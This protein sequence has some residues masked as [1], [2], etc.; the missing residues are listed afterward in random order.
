MSSSLSST[1][2]QARTMETFL[3]RRPFTANARSPS[4]SGV[5]LEN[6]RSS[7]E[8]CDDESQGSNISSLRSSIRQ[9]LQDEMQSLSRLQTKVAA[10]TERLI[11]AD[12]ELEAIESVAEDGGSSTSLGKHG[13]S[14]PLARDKRSTS[15]SRMASP[16]P[17][18]SD[19][20]GLTGTASGK[21]NLTLLP[22][23][24]E[25]AFE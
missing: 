14:S 24:R 16:S 12:A 11:L 22:T 7:D 25:D 1:T 21:E 23:C 15:P 9:Q 4:P 3:Q 10:L 20:G 17:G 19:G 13:G 2:S 5:L 6:I 8:G 18:E